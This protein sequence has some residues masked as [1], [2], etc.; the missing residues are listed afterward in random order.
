[1][2]E[3]EIMDILSNK[4]WRKDGGGLSAKIKTKNLWI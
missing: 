2:L 4:L 1:M 3:K